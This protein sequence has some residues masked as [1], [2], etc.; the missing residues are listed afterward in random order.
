MT[1][2]KTHATQ[3]AN[4][5]RE[6]PLQPGFAVRLP[7]SFDVSPVI[8]EIEALGDEPWRIHFNT[9]YHDGGWSGLV[10]QSPGGDDSTLYSRVRDASH[11]SIATTGAAARCPALMQL[12]ASFQCPVKTARVLRLAA[13]SVIREHCDADLRWGDGEARLH[14]PL[15]TNPDVA[16]HVDGQRVRMLVGECWY[17]NLSKPHRVHNRGVTDRLHLVLDCSV[18]DWLVNQVQ[19]GTAPTAA[20]MI[21]DATAQFQVFREV[22]FADHSLQE[23]LRSCERRDDLLA[24]CVARGKAL[25]YCFSVDDVT[26][27]M[28]RAQR[29]WM[30]QWI[31]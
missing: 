3:T 17:L 24:L 8:A 14:I 15:L 1:D 19:H 22:V 26:A 5:T 16:F 2:P 10:L 27:Q 21:D 23:A 30:E 6:E 28:N 29:E 20:S 4:S 11:E 25:G 7:L 13:G 31:R 18:N 9:G 12:V